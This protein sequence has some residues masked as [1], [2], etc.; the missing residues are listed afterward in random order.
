M[1]S[2]N[3]R[4]CSDEGN[5][6]VACCGYNDKMASCR[7]AMKYFIW[8]IIMRY[9]AHKRQQGRKKQEHAEIPSQIGSKRC[10]QDER[11]PEIIL[12]WGSLRNAKQFYL[13][14]API[15]SFFQRYI[16]HI[17]K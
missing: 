11:E 14:F 7:S 8:A 1:R 2:E 9:H 12:L 4:I 15:F 10:L 16:V 3:Q 17:I 13:V 5:L 6:N